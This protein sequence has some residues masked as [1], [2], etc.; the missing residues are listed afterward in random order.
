M[1][2]LGRRWLL[3]GF[4]VASLA[5]VAALSAY[6][7]R[8][9]SGAGPI[10]DRTSFARRLQGTPDGDARRY[11]LFYATTR[12]TDADNRAFDGDGQRM[13][14]HVTS[15]GTFEVRISPRLPIAPRVWFET[16][17]MKMVGRTELSQDEMLA[18]L[19]DAV[20]ASPEKSLLVIV[21]GF[22]DWFESA[23]LK[24]AYTAYVLDIN[25]PVLLFDWPGNQ[26]EGPNGY[27]ASQRVSEQ[28]APILGQVV[29]R[30]ER[31]T[32]VE[33]LWVIGS[34]LGCQ[35][36]VDAISWMMT[37]PD[38]VAG[39][40]KIDHV[41]LSAPDVPANEFNE[42][43]AAEITT[44]ARQLTVYVASNDQALL[45]SKWVN[46]SHRLGRVPVAQPEPTEEDEPQLQGAIN[47]L[48]LQA[49]GA[50]N[51]SVVDATPI[52]RTRNLHHFFTDSPEFFD[53]LFRGLLQP[54]NPLGRRLYPIR[55][56]Q[57]ST[58][59]LLWD[60]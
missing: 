27:L 7:S 14:D 53:D 10:P 13:S 51:I 55:T 26:G 34:S 56:E 4:Y 54:D 16:D 43:F 33:R 58:F 18:R 35:T 59:W 44:L 38:L 28:A 49:K 42:R 48:D 30:V 23:A 6:L 1:R 40:P 39:G 50:H 22:R 52:N 5:A 9:L 45:T 47:L 29:A 41:V 19:R 20:A 32:G 31:E 37:Q 11:T 12:A 57:G 25:T 3:A 17:L 36:I 24:T 46:R 60:Y 8:N 15:T 21:W 2:L